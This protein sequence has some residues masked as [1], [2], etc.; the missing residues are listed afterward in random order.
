M[1]DDL[2]WIPDPWR[3]RLAIA[4]RPRGGD[5]LDD[6][7]RAWRRAGIDVVVSLLE[8][9]ETA[10]LDLIAEERIA[11]GQ[12]ISF[13]SFPIPDRGVPEST[14]AAV[15]VIGRIAEQLESGRNVAV[16]CRQGIGRS[17]LIAAAV[18]MHSGL[19]PEKAI[20]IVSA[21]RGIAIPETVEQ[22]R[23]VDQLRSRVPAG[24][25]SGIRSVV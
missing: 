2:F 10:Q 15:E 11:E 13:I 4:A 3:G 18:L 24:N 6:E 25:E 12:S 21:A 14:E 19:R 1:K 8:D 9:D 20:E 7:V 23:W 17:G 16:H 22:R 5:W